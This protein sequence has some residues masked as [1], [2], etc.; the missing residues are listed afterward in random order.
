MSE[1]RWSKEAI[2]KSV[3]KENI[4]EEINYFIENGYQKNIECKEVKTRSFKILND[5]KYADIILP[6]KYIVCS[7]LRKRRKEGEPK[8]NIFN[9]NIAISII[10]EYFGK[11][12][13]EE[14]ENNKRSFTD[15]ELDCYESIAKKYNLRYHCSSGKKYFQIYP[16]NA[17]ESEG[18][19]GCHY[20]FEIQ[21]NQKIL[22]VLHFEKKAKKKTL[23][24]ENIQSL[25][26]SKRLPRQD[27]TE[28][29]CDEI[30]G[31]FKQLYDKVE[32]P[33]N[34]FYDQDQHPFSSGNQSGEKTMKET[35]LNQILYGPPGTGKTYN[36]IN[37]ALEIILNLSDDYNKKS[38][39]EK[40]KELVVQSLLAL[41]KEQEENESNRDVLK[42]CY[43][44]YADEEQGQIEFITFHQSYGYEEFVEGIKAIPPGEKGNPNENMIYKVQKGIFSKLSNIA[45]EALELFDESISNPLVF[46]EKSMFQQKTI[47]FLEDSIEHGKIFHL[48]NKQK[49]SD[50]RPSFYIDSFD[51]SEIR[52]VSSSSSHR[53]NIVIK[54]SELTKVFLSK[55]EITNNKQSAQINGY[56]RGR[57]EDSYILVILENLKKFDFKTTTIKKEPKKNYILIIDE[58][59]RGNISKIFGELITLIEPSKRIGSKEKE[60]LTLKLPYSSQVF[61]VPSNLYIIGTMNTADRSISPIDTAL[62]RRFIFEEM[63][64]KPNLLDKDIKDIDLNKMLTAINARIEYLYDRDHTIGHSYFMGINEYDDLVFVMHNQIIPLL[65]EY[66]YEDWENIKLILNNNDFITLDESND[67]LSEEV[68]KKI[69]AKKIYK[70]N[71]LLKYD[72][73][74][75]LINDFKL[76]YGD[77][78]KSSGNNDSETSTAKVEDEQSKEKIG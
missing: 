57:Q 76:I 67:Y 58:I 36:T 27:V 72:K 31:L 1:E 26:E 30:N 11:S 16:R 41:K 54:I 51:E 60:D 22:L 23:F 28:L 17:S 32:V 63:L 19:G 10:N 59:N 6:T 47:Q 70:I 37:K 77:D 5:E 55:E 49:G 2:L 45:K 53:E 65:A 39:K 56:K 50:E 40:E 12:N 13:I 64:P 20:E 14:V 8:S 29:D 18:T 7:S 43:D 66:F 38:D 42:A 74:K 69:Y 9:P 75:K 15:K 61:G 68:K 71:D 4:I 21:G 34:K 35:P 3:S 48:R 78:A 25:F 62:R 44:H 24:L 73:D 46:E 52:I 33:I